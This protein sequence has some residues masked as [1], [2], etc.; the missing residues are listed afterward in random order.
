MTQTTQLETGVELAT[1]FSQALQ[2]DWVLGRNSS[3]RRV[4]QHLVRAAEVECTVLVSGETGTGKELFARTL[5]AL[6]PRSG[7]PFIPVN[8]AALTATLAESQLF[9]HE[10]G[11]FTGA[12]GSS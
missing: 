3:I 12:A 11:A 7:R 4:A 1:T 8:C 2:S 6:G 10:R 5:H 9:G